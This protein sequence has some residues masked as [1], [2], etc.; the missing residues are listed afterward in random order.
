MGLPKLN[1][2]GPDRPM[3]HVMS[4]VENAI[5]ELLDKCNAQEAE[6]KRLREALRAGT[7]KAEGRDR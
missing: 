4:D 1:R 7:G 2:K 5:R 3:E 6:I